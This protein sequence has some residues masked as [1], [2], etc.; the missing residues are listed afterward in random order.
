LDHLDRSAD[1]QRYV[2]YLEKMHSRKYD[3]YP[4][5][6]TPIDPPTR[7]ATE[8]NSPARPRRVEKEVREEKKGGEDSKRDNFIKLL[9]KVKNRGESLLVKLHKFPSHKSIQK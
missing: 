7:H 8:G 9:R 1:F 2:D 5:A 4:P 3:A 6:R